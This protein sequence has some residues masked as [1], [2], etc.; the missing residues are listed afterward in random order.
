MS[1]FARVHMLSYVQYNETKG[2]YETYNNRSDEYA[3]HINNGTYTNFAIKTLLDGQLIFLV[4]IWIMTIPDKWTDVFLTT[5][6]C[7]IN[8]NNITM[9]YDGMNSSII[10]KQADVLLNIFPLGPF[11]KDRTMKIH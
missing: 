10:T 2:L 6:T 7:P 11:N 5:C 9:E 8:K 3:N 4:N 1:V